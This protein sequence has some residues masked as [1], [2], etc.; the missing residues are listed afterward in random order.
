MHQH[1]YFLGLQSKGWYKTGFSP[2]K[3]EQREKKLSVNIQKF[4]AR[5]EAE[6]NQKKLEAELKKK[7]R[8]FI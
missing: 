8:F 6:E 4:L 2:P 5:K 1:R 7:V 3:K